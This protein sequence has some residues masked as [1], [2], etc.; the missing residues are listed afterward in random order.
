[1]GRVSVSFLLLL[2]LFYTSLLLKFED[3]NAL[4]AGNYFFFFKSGFLEK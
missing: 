4:F 2:I 1:V 3:I